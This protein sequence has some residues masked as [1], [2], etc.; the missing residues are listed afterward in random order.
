MN[1][2]I[3]IIQSSLLL[4]SL[5]VSLIIVILIWIFKNLKKY[6]S[7]ATNKYSTSFERTIGQKGV[8]KEEITDSNDLGLVKV[9]GQIWSAISDVQIKKGNKVEVVAVSGSKLIV[10]KVKE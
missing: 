3:E 2:I 9:N 10:K 8:V 1:E 4:K 5:V 7:K 6:D